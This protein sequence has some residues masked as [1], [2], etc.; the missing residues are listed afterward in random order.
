MVYYGK[1]TQFILK[2]KDFSLKTESA[3]FN[4]EC[5]L[6]GPKVVLAFV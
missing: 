3:A 6:I 4:E 1:L 2:T 5:F